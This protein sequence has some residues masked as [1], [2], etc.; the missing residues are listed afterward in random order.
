MGYNNLKQQLSTGN[1][2]Q[3]ILLA[4]GI[5]FAQNFN[6]KGWYYTQSNWKGNGLANSGVGYVGNNRYTNYVD[7]ANVLSSMLG[8]NNTK[9]KNKLQLR[10]KRRLGCFI[11][12]L[13]NKT[14]AVREGCRPHEPAQVSEHLHNGM[15]PHRKTSIPFYRSFDKLGF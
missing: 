6:P 9:Y 4:G 5:G 12:V 2:L 14:T 15:T 11:L 10:L 3:D 7:V 1:T 8:D 13:E